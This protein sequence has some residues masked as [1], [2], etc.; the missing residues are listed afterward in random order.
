MPASAIG[1]Y[2]IRDASWRPAYRAV[3]NKLVAKHGGRYVARTTNPSE[4]LEGA[5]PD[6][7]NITM[8]EFPSM[9]RARA[10]YDDPE[11]TPMKRLR[12]A[13]S[14]RQRSVP[15]TLEDALPQA[16]LL[17]LSMHDKPQHGDS[18]GEYY[19]Q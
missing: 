11:Y 16:M 10:W 1:L 19:E 7:T 5:A 14:Y 8:I 2:H 3:V 17:F 18:N 4:V 9:E 12:Q 13:G 15:G 6:V